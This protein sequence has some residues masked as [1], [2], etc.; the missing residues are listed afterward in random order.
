MTTAV[1]VA[2]FGGSALGA[3]GVLIPKIMDR[4][5]QIMSE[6]KVVAVFSAPMIEYD[7]KVSS[8]TDVA[9][10]VGRNYASS[11]PV[12]I[13]VLREVYERIATRYLDEERKKAFLDQLD[14][15]YRQVII[16]LKVAAENRR[17]VDVI[18]S[19]TLAYS[20]EV[21]MSYLMGYV[22]QAH[23]IKAAHVP[24]E[25]WPIITDDNFEAANFMASESRQNAGHLIELVESN[26]VVSMGGFI[27]KTADGL[28]TTYE[29]GGSDRTAADIAIILSGDKYE[30][31]I[32][33][34]KDSAV[35]SA[36]PKIVKDGLDFVPYLS[37]NEARIAGM[38]GM[39]IL[40][41]IAIK[42]IDDNGLDIPL[43]VTN[44]T[45]PDSVTVIKRTPPSDDQSNPIKIVTG[46]KNCAIVRMETIAASHL[47]AS[48]ESDRQYHEFV[49]L[50]P[51]VKDD[52]EMTRLLFL[53]AD[54]VRRHER[55]FRAYYQKAEIVY[56]RAVVT[57]IGDE[58]WR[59]PKIASTASSNV[60]EHDI[61]ILNLD[62]QEETSRI[63]I[64]VEDKANSVADAVKAIHHTRVKM[65]GRRG[66]GGSSGA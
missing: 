64:V 26:D 40:D 25:H 48:L 27:G 14:K 16:S 4:L 44:M 3:D 36:D 19:R 61:N 49:K 9:I 28:E 15:F 12:E 57:L 32:S 8:M 38:F 34:E 55:H 29:R 54:Y 22:M 53:D 42:E 2:K 17:F 60:S 18:R 52:V 33:F 30:T 7:G 37:Y 65:H 20:G 43:V 50:S 59:V 63:L 39:K 58:M 56:G 21:T 41:P 23:G 47:I 1:T 51:Y 35:L 10:K 13:E 6:S 62:A 31:K 46:K 5:K 45:R 11:N 24:I 66:G